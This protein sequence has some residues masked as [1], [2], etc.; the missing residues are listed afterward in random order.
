MS[1]SETLLGKPQ[2]LDDPGLFHRL[3]LIAFFAW[4]G[5]GADG[6]S[7]SA[8]GPEEAFKALLG[9]EYLAVFL[10]VAM[11]GTVF[12]LSFAYSRIIEHFPHGGGGY[13]V[14]TKL[15]G[16]KAGLVSGCALLVDYVL[17][18]TISVA[19]GV[20]A[21][22]AFLPG[23]LQA[24]KMPAKIGVVLVLM[25]MNLRGTKES[26]KILTPIFMAFLLTHFVLII[27][28]LISF[29]SGFVALPATVTTG[30]QTDLSTIG[31]FGILHLFTLA[32]SLGGGTYTG[33]EAVSNGISIMREPQVETAKKTMVYMA[34]SLALTAGGIL[35]CYLLAGVTAGGGQPMNAILASKFSGGWTLA[36]L[37]VGHWFAIV[38]LISEGA[39][40]FVAAQ[41]GFIDGPRVMANL[42]VD[43]WL[44][45]QFA[46]LSEQLTMRN[47]VYLMSGAALATLLYTHGQVHF[48]VVMYSINVFITFALSNLGMARLWLRARRTVE[49]WRR[50][51]ALH[52]LTVG[53]CVTILVVTIIEKFTHGGWVTLLIT[54]STIVFCLV[55]KQHYNRVATQLAKLNRELTEALAGIPDAAR[56]DLAMD[57]AKPTAVLMVAGFSAVGIHTL[58]KVQQFFPNHFRQVVFVSVGA[59]D[60][61]VFKGAGETEKLMQSVKNQMDR[62]VAVTT[63]KMNWAAEYEVAIGIDLVE[64]LE[65]LCRKVYARYP[66]SVFF[67]GKL[68]FREPSWWHKVFHNETAF[69]VQRRLGLE[70]LPMV[71]IPVRVPW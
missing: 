71:V 65:N 21:L 70:G 46:S 63:H 15:L 20:N 68:V 1:I 38:T 5:L 66:R 28:V 54:G 2:K 59:I 10:A 41:T 25:L 57:P 40:L 61:G 58:F 51:T 55:S 35:L 22:F 11:A 42:A 13:L 44:P 47:G 18:I 33:I 3:S 23:T 8:Y 56:S 37:P 29:S 53:L 50:N 4:V 49:K 34:V 6:L 16:P 17:T 14:S 27:G 64:E 67:S 39:L 60:S 26:V 62:Y 31:A 36:G 9:H 43:G 45:K 24:W 48:L 30:L 32:Y 69:A 7:S 12:L 19:A 52:L